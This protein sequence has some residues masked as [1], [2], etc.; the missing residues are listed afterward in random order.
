MIFSSPFPDA[1][2][3]E[4]PLVDFVF[5]NAASHADKPALIDGTTGRIV[6]YGRL[7]DEIRAVARGLADSG[8]RRG[9][10]VAIFGP[11][12]PDYVTTFYGLTTLG[13]CVTTLNPLHNIAELSYQLK[14][15]AANA[16]VT[17]SPATETVVAAATQA[18]LARVFDV[19]QLA[20][21]LSATRP[22]SDLCSEVDVHRDIATLT[23]SNVATDVPMGV[24]LSHYNLVANV[25]QTYSVE[26]IQA[27]EVLVGLMPFCQLYGMVTVN[28]ALSA[29]ATIVTLPH[30]T[31]PS[32][33]AAMVRYQVTTAFLVPSIIRTLTKH[34]VADEHS[35]SSL[36]HVVSL[37][38]PLPEPVGRAC[39]EK[40]GC[41][42]PTGV[43]PD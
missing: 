22:S 14:D 26:P 36:R 23:Y 16:L 4:V 35:L 2:I 1:R 29:G 32:L 38:A 3:P 18:G 43:R 7:G 17:T 21:I 9:D 11:N 40:F 41:T 33:M 10:V 39:A 27:D 20:R 30:F 31:L 24:M 37:T 5:E 42:G 19:Q 8:V 13:A 25:A 6:S 15:S 28:L 12:S 34:A